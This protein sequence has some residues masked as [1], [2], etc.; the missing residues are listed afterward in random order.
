MK[1]ILIFGDS[2]TYGVGG[3]HGSWADKIKTAFH[4]DMYG[5]KMT[6]GAHC[7]VYELGIPGETMTNILDRF[8]AETTSRIRGANPQDVMIVFSAGTNDSK[9]VEAADNHLFTPDDFAASVHAFIHLAK[10]YAAHIVGVGLFPVDESKTN[11]FPSAT[12]S[13]TYF[14]NARLSIFDEAFQRTCENEGVYFV[15]LFNAV[16]QDWAQNNLSIDGLH[17]NDRGHE[18]IRAQI[19]PELRKI[20]GLLA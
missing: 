10:E 12:R 4:A 15:P 6:T 13:G 9:A 8:V 1:T 3:E 14:S 11:P 19:E 16:P 17:P 18:W 2:E 7:D 5:Q 20:T